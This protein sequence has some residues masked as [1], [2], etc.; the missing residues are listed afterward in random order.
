MK[1][2]ECGLLTGA[3]REYY[4]GLH[5]APRTDVERILACMSDDCIFGGYE[6][7]DEAHAPATTKEEIR[8]KY[9]RMAQYIPCCVAMRYETL[10]DDGRTCVIEWVHIISKGSSRKVVGLTETR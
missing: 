10:T 5:R 6:P 3:V 2:G 1:S 7:D 8:A 9:E 4:E